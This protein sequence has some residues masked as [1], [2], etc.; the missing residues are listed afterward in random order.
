MS[1]YIE[2]SFFSETFYCSYVH[3][4]CS[5]VHRRT[6]LH[7][8]KVYIFSRVHILMG[9]KESAKYYDLFGEKPDI[10]YYQNLGIEYGSALE[11]GVG[12]G[13]VAL[14]LAKAGI[15]VWGIDNC[16]EMLDIARK[17]VA[18]QPADVQKRTFLTNA[19]MTDFQLARTFPLIYVPSSAVNH[20][21]TTEDQLKFLA[22]VFNHL[23]KGGLFAFDIDLPRQSYSTA[24]TLIDKKEVGDTLVVRWISN[25]PD[26]SNQTVDT[27]LVFECYKN[28]NLTERTIETSTISLIYKRE[29]FLL[30]ESAHFRIE[31]VY[32]DFEKGVKGSDLLVIEARGP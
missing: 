30:L 19:E 1:S 2:F 24:L 25:R 12:T 18:E 26:F 22:C 10:P 15:E 16:E 9:Y 4:Y 7:E 11:V 3:S 8:K 6:Q 29:L 13:R 32:G 23:Q 27:T 31:H 28:Q 21:I 17:K 20:C 14:E 5:Y